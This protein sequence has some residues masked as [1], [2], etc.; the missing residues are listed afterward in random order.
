ML[1]HSDMLQGTFHPV[2]EIAYAGTE[3]T[4]KLRF[5]VSY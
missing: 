4:N 1:F 5:S 2:M 3:P